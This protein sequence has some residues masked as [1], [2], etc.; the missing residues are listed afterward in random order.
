VYAEILF[1]NILRLLQ[2]RGMTKQQLSEQSGV[3]IS[4]LTDLTQGRANPSLETMA[5]IATALEATLPE[6][7]ELHE[8]DRQLLDAA[9]AA[10]FPVQ[11]PPGFV[12]ITAV[13]PAVKAFTVRKWDVDARKRLQLLA[14]DK[15]KPKPPGR[16]PRKSS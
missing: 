4:F 12:R 6:L 2:L 11:L 14:Q 8:T 5:T 16:S 15:P 10:L 9:D 13:L 7:L 3:S 1:T